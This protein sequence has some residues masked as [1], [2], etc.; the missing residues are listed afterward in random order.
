MTSVK[1]LSE[2]TVLTEPFDGYQQ[3][4]AYRMRSSQ[5]DP[6]TPV[7]R[8]LPRSLMVPPGIPEFFTRRR[9][10]PA[11]E[12]VLQGR[13]WSGHG[14]I[15]RV[16]VSD[17]AGESWTDAELGEPVGPHAWHGWRSRW[18]ATA[19]EHVLCCRAEDRA[20]HVQPL[21]P[22]WN[23]GGYA[24]NAVHRVVAVVG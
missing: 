5:D 13:A 10:V 17:D 22:R 19:G 24:N 9:H 1:W 16:Q 11:G 8:M 2:M 12:H 7:T 23:P 21:Q 6:G 20:G 15:A 14:P 3:T 4:T 18:A